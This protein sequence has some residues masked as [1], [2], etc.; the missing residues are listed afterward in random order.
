MT[1]L[2]NLEQKVAQLVTMHKQI[3]EENRDLRAQAALLEAENKR[4]DGKLSSA[5]ERVDAL[6][7]QMPDTPDET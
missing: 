7:A 4:L 5:R 3:K 2:E 1:E 6:L